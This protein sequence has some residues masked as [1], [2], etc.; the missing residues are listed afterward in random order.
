MPA[1]SKDTLPLRI[2]M[3]AND[4]RFDYKTLIIDENEIIEK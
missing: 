1:S 2:A 3:D 4:L